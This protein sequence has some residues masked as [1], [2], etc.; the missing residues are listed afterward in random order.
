M[1]VNILTNV[2]FVFLGWLYQLM[3][4]PNPKVMFPLRNFS[5]KEMVGNT[6]NLSM[7]IQLEWLN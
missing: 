4:I 3:K 1:R 5:L 2:L 7:D 6:E